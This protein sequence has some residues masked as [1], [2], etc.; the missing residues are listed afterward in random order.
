MRNRFPV[1]EQIIESPAALGVVRREVPG[2]SRRDP[3]SVMLVN[4]NN[5]PFRHH[6][7]GASPGQCYRPA[8]RV[9][10]PAPQKPIVK[11]SRQH[12]N[13]VESRNP[14]I[15]WSPPGVLLGDLHVGHDPAFRCGWIQWSALPFSWWCGRGWV[16]LTLDDRECRFSL[17]LA[18]GVAGIGCPGCG[19]GDSV[20]ATP[21]VVRERIRATR[22]QKDSLSDA[23]GRSSHPVPYRPA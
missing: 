23:Y 4:R 16:W 6:V 8:R 10:P 21:I 5:G 12:A 13:L 7:A 9:R 2:E 3:A 15:K 17:A 1:Y 14:A 18:V 19:I 22:D 11:P 20:F